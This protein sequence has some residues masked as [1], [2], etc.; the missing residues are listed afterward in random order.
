MK[1][2]ALI[3]AIYTIVVFLGCMIVTLFW[4]RIP[5]LLDGEIVHY[6]LLRGVYWFLKVLPVV[7]LSGFCVACSIVWQKAPV[8]QKPFSEI[9]SVRYR[10]IMI[11]S[12]ALV[13]V[14]TLCAEIFCP[15]VRNRLV[16]ME[17]SPEKLSTAI[18]NAE[19]FLEDDEPELA[20]Q[21][22][23]QA[24]RISA[25]SEGAADVFKRASDALEIKRQ[26]NKNI[27]ADMHE[28]KPESGFDE[29]DENLI[30]PFER[31][32][33]E[34]D[35]GYTIMELLQKSRDASNNHN[36]VNAHYWATLAY[37]L[38]SGTDT[39][40]EIA[41]K[42]ANDAWNAL[43]DPIAEEDL[44][45]KQLYQT[46]RDGYLAFNSGD[47]LKAY[48]TFLELKKSS[49]KSGYQDPDVERF[50][51][52]SLEGVKAQ[53][54]FFDETEDLNRLADNHNVY[55]AIQN[56]DGT[57]DVVYIKDTMELKRIGGVVR[58]LED[59]NIVRF[60]QDGSFVMSMTVPYAKV[61]A[62]SVEIFDVDTREIMGIDKK[63]KTIPMI[64]LCSVDR[65]TEGLVSRPKYSNS[66]SGI[67]KEFRG[68]LNLFQLPAAYKRSEE[69]NS[70][71]AN[72][73]FDEKSN[74]IFLSIP[75]E[76]FGLLGDV[77][78]GPDEMPFISLNTFINKAL[79][80]GFSSEEY[81]L[82][83][84]MRGTYPLILL[85]LFILMAI[86]GWNYRIEKRGKKDQ[87][88]FIWL[89]HIPAYGLIM[90][91]VFDIFM[92]MVKL[93]EYVLV[94][95]SGTASIVIAG[96]ID[97]VLLVI[98]SLIFLSRVTK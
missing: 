38:C 17:Q 73:L 79:E 67:P 24:L 23:Q 33:Y 32:Q 43:N 48:Y 45:K 25:K 46:K 94:T 8:V 69:V 37:S 36:Y 28:Y 10:K 86:M 51:E 90:Y 22:G 62:T 93:L 70:V 1:K 56:A 64:M 39:N 61:I 78:K 80:Y 81:M 30:K 60:D 75:F 35:K 49:D 95:F 59:L 50:L 85:V 40:R 52:L 84:V 98:F 68:K 4:G 47:Y 27:N 54:F 29:S 44:A 89:F 12:I 19:Y 34:A 71:N 74:I 2:S 7:F 42:Y 41:I 57:K 13:F 21:Y 63:W 3:M 87:F 5:P 53:Y 55:F 11:I 26:R 65:M 18:A 97:F 14:L 77:S 58:Y 76:D 16:V 83:F 6:R 20:Y 96:A 31:T 92:Y 15:S 66:V 9:M 72:Y 82:S 88:K 91:F